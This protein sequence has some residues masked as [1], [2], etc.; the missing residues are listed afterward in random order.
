M[1]AGLSL[2]FQLKRIINYHN[3]KSIWI[4]IIE[5]TLILLTGVWN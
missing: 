5:I 4:V 1:I 2:S 3:V